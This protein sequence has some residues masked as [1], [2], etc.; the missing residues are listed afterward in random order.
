MGREG[1]ILYLLKGIRHKASINPFSWDRYWMLNEHQ[2][3]VMGTFFSSGLLQPMKA[4]DL[5]T[6]TC[7]GLD[8]TVVPIM[9]AMEWH[10]KG[11]GL[12]VL[13]LVFSSVALGLH[14]EHPL[15]PV[16]VLT[17]SSPLNS[18]KV[19]QISLRWLKGWQEVQEQMGMFS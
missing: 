11:L 17:F 1:Q 2:C 15:S 19:T 8:V 16:T 6:P 14:F 4:W 12:Q 13:T 18:W 3:S 10:A 7:V 9:M 5:I